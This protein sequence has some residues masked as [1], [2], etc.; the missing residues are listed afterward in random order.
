MSVPPTAYGRVSIRAR[1]AYWLMPT[2]VAFITQSVPSTKHRWN[3]SASSAGRQ[4]R[5]NA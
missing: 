2:T 4:P 5:C 1:S 3:Q